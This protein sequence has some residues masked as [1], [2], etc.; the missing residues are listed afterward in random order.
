MKDIKIRMGNSSDIPELLPLMAQLG[1]PTTKEE[2][3]K[4][5]ESF[6]S[7]D[8][9]AIAVAC[10]EGHIVGW[11]AWSTSKLFIL[12]YTRI[13]IEG[14]IVD[15]HYRRQGIGKKL[16]LFVEEVAKK[17]R[18]VTIDLTSGLRRAKDGSHDFY[19]SL[20]YCNEGYM[21]KLYL[22]KEID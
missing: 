16:M 13:R 7:F 3:L 1:Y 4:R 15:N 22:K 19:K 5:Y 8:G 20:G 21:A 12:D 11:V 14:L 18:P 6:V 10:H 17:F 9:H 2:L